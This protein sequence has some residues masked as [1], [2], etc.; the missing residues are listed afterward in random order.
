MIRLNKKMKHII[1]LIA[2]TTI[3][4]GCRKESLNT[5]VTPSLP[6]TVR[7][8]IVPQVLTIPLNLP[9]KLQL[10]A[11]Q[12]NGDIIDITNDKTVIWSSD[13]EKIIQITD[14]GI[15]NGLIEGSS[16][17]KAE[18]VNGGESYK[19]SIVVT[20]IN[21][22][23]L[24]IKIQPDKL[25]IAKGNK[26]T[27]KATAFFSGDLNIDITKNEQTRWFSDDESIVRVNNSSNKGEIEGIEVGS[28]N[29][30][31][32][33]VFDGSLFNSTSVIDVSSA[34]VLDFQIIQKDGYDYVVKNKQRQFRALATLSDGSSDVDITSSDDLIWS[35][36]DPNLATVSNDSGNKGN[37]F[38]KEL[39]SDSLIATFN[40]KVKKF[41]FKV[42]SFYRDPLLIEETII[43]EIDGGLNNEILYVD[44]YG[45][46]VSGPGP[47]I[48]SYSTLKYYDAVNEC[49]NRGEV[50]ASN[51]MQFR[52]FMNSHPKQTTYWPLMRGFWTSILD[53]S[54]AGGVFDY[55]L[56]VAER[57]NSGIFIVYGQDPNSLAFI[58][59]ERS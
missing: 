21:A 49:K 22:A 16:N 35:T 18:W 9:Y 37:V 45:N 38:G 7:I 1:M 57:D 15:I 54:W 52:N 30:N 40:G 19:D 44:E 51:Q 12:N 48:R 29:V 55:H 28:T 27:L 6:E 39:G 14:E 41:P 47:G 13:N 43:D 23:L 17:I 42:E 50:L 8:L 3:M 2:L 31:T 58:V 24:S 34:E 26:Q 20:T 32:E 36:S 25:T 46:E 33:L 10:S 4:F 59:C 53:S 56:Q 5:I 11:I